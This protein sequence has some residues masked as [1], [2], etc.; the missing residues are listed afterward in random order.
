VGVTHDPEFGPLIMFG[1][2]GAYVELV[3][4]VVFRLC[5]LTDHDIESML[6]SVRSSELLKG[7]RGKPPGDVAAIKDLLSRVS[8]MV[9]DIPELLEMDLNPVKILAPGRGCVV[10]DA[11]MRMGHPLVNPFANIR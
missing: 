5:P 3:R 2:G 10:V 7:Y 6:W 1:L 4:D 9:A 11:R 8:Q